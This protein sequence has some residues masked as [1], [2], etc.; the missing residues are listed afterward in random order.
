MAERKKRAAVSWATCKAAL[1]D[2]PQ[3]GVVE[4]VHELYKQS[5]QNR[6]FLH[7]R[8]M[9]EKGTEAAA[10]AAGRQMLKLLS[11][12]AVY[13]G[14]F[15][16]IELKKIVDTFDKATDDKA[17]VARLLVLDLAN[18]VGTFA[19]VGDFEPMVDHCY[20]TMT[21]LDTILLALPPA[22][23]IGIVDQLAAIEQRYRDK[24]G[25]GLGDE[26]TGQVEEWRV[27]L[28]NALLPPE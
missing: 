7:A 21:R 24:F 3:R 9:P 19:E 28:G 26:L 2:W 23:A 16:H 5:E 1:K 20:A 6:T 25:Y 12:A 10:A 17:A 8:V 27:R 11:P 22:E 15:R 13:N 4:L 14:R 18:S